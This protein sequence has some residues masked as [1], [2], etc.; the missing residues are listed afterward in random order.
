M[1]LYH[2]VAGETSRLVTERYS[3]SFSLASRLFGPDIRPHIYHIYGLVRVADEVVDTYRGKDQA[4]LLDALETEVYAATA[5]GFSTNLIVDA[6]ALTAAKYHIGRDL[7][8]PF[9]A[10]MRRDITQ[11][12][13]TP[14]ELGDYIYGSAEVVGLMCLKV[15]TAGNAG[16]YA[17]LKPGAQALG[18][19]FQKVNFL[20]DLSADHEEL[21][22]VYFP[23]V[24]WESFNDDAKRRVEADI[25][26]DFDAAYQAIMALSPSARPAVLAAYRYY[27]ALLEKIQATPAAALKAGRLRVPTARKLMILASTGLASRLGG[28]GGAA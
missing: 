14:S 20:R 11:H 1:D 28:R 27:R 22:R 21:G 17:K 15:F 13:Y 18:A 10:S 19:A 4:P 26:A 25:A 5:R 7:I 24:K 23:G 8:E 3:T 12:N 2:R 16:S 6:F 9:F